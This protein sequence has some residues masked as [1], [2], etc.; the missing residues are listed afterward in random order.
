LIGAG[1]WS[2]RWFQSASPRA[3]AELRFCHLQVQAFLA[4]RKMEAEYGCDNLEQ[5]YLKY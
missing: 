5:F 4:V 2:R 3:K 1:S